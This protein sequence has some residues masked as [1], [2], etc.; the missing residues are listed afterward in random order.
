MWGGNLPFSSALAISVGRNLPVSI[1]LAI[2]LYNSLYCRWCTSRDP[3]PSFQSYHGFKRFIILLLLLLFNSH[4]EIQ[5]K[6]INS[7]LSCDDN[8]EQLK[9]PSLTNSNSNK[10]NNEALSWVEI[11]ESALCETTFLVA[12]RMSVTA[13]REQQKKA[14]RPTWE[15]SDSDPVTVRLT[16][17]RT[18]KIIIS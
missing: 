1:A 9:T 3:I 2:G 5:I 11:C 10:S 14:L 13:Y 17:R 16:V 18:D 6:S 12:D 4:Q 8:R 7:S 15:F